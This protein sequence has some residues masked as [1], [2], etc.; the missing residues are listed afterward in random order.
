MSTETNKYLPSGF[1]GWFLWVAAALG[2][3]GAL[4]DLWMREYYYAAQFALFAIY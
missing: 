1:W 4:H 2:M 3:A